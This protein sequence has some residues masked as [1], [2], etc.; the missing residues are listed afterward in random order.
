MPGT[1]I[2]LRLVVGLRFQVLFH[3]PHWGAFHLSLTVLVHYRSSNVFSLGKWTSRF[4][5][6][7]ACPVV[8]RNTDR[9]PVRFRVRD[10][11]PLWLAFPV[12]FHYQPDLSLLEAFAATS[13]G[14]SNPRTATP[15]SYHAARVWAFPL[16]LATTQGMISF[17]R[18][19]K[20]FQFPRFPPTCLWI[21]QVVPGHSPRWVSPFGH[22]RINACRG[23][24]RLIAANHALHRRLTPRHPP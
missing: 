12:P 18:G 21:Q 22:P 24:P 2:V 6:G 10:Y 1:A 20:M 16:S 19:T 11:H 14:S 7:L 15:A 8:L 5:T 9:S 23:S 4:P 17:P 3:S 13:I